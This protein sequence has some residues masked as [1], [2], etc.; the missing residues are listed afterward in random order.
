MSVKLVHK[1]VAMRDEIKLSQEGNRKQ[2]K[3]REK[4]KR[5]PDA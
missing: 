1:H 5:M 2:M 4:S 3:K